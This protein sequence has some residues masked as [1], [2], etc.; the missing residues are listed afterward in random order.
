[1][2]NFKFIWLSLLLILPILGC[3]DINRN[4]NNGNN[5]SGNG[6]NFTGGGPIITGNVLG[7][8]DGYDHEFWSNGIATGQ[9]TVGAKGTFQCNWTSNGQGS[10]ILFR[11]GKRFGA[12]QPHNQIGNI[13]F[14]YSAIYN[15]VSPG[16]SYL[17]VYGWTREPLVEYYIV[18]NYLS[19]HPGNWNSPTFLGSFTIPG[20]GTYQVFRTQMNNA[21]SIDGNGKNFPQYISVRTEKRSSGTISVSKHFDEWAKLGLDMSGSL[22]EAMMKVEG[23]NNSGTATLTQ[24]TL[25]ITK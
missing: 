18:E 1:M 21:P 11:S 25:T 23:Y 19:G 2:K 5:E 17:S 16:Q 13:T 6:D 7:T 15:P 22:Y 9:M 20:E 8:Y 3:G 24:N 10:N 12:T 4:N 14:T